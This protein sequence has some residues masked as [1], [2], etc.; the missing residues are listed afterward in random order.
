MAVEE[1]QD[2]L[3]DISIIICA[4]NEENRIRDCLEKCIEIK[5]REIIVIVGNSFDKTAAIAHEFATRVVESSLGS[6]SKDRQLGI[7]LSTGKYIL[8][9]DADHRIDSKTAR[10]LLTD[11]AKYS[12]DAVQAQIRQQSLDSLMSRSEA[13]FLKVFYS[14]TGPRNMIGTAPTLYKRKIFDNICFNTDQRMRIDDTDFIYRLS[15]TKKFKVGL[16]SAVVLQDHDTSFSSYVKKFWWYGEGDYDFCIAHKNRAASILYHVL[17]RYPIVYGFTLLLKGKPDGY[18]YCVI[19][20]MTRFAS[21]M[22]Q[23]VTRFFRN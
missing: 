21:I 5:S 16:G 14:K 3:S 22:F 1:A 10:V 20:G 4:K 15:L 17:L 12:L 23:L 19:H 6:L 8:M 9:V 7:S 11:L 13:T 18:L 2:E